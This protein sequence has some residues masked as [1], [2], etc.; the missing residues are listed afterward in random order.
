MFVHMCVQVYV[1][2]WVMLSSSFENIQ[3]SVCLEMWISKEFFFSSV[4]FP[5]WKQLSGE[6][7]QLTQVS[8]Y[9]TMQ[10]LNFTE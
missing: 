4:R 2:K 10:S 3:K 7:D 8:A 5:E 6:F 1:Y 9:S